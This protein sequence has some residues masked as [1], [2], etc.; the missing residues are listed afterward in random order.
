MHLD[1]TAV[2][3]L[4]IMISNFCIFS[5]CIYWW[6]KYRKA[7]NIFGCFTLLS[8]GI[9][10]NYLPLFLARAEVVY[11]S[12][13]ARQTWWWHCRPIPIAIA[14]VLIL[15]IFIYRLFQPEIVPTTEPVEE[16]E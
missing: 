9:F 7:S 10:V 14:S 15:G 12:D 4:I 1:L 5:I 11:L 16:V 3:Y 2:I 6:W 13:A 8:G